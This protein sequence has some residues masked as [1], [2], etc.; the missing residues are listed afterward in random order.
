MQDERKRILAL[1]EKG[2][3]SATEALD[4]LEKIDAEKQGTAQPKQPFTTTEKPHTEQTSKHEE[5]PFSFEEEKSEKQ[6][7]DKTDEE[8]IDE[9]KKD[10]TQ[11]SSKFMDM[12]TTAVTKVR[13]FDFTGEKRQF[14]KRYELGNDAI[15]NV[16]VKV[17][18]GSFEI[19]ESSS[20]EAY[21][22]VEVVPTLL[23]RSED[24]ESDFEGLFTA[25]N[26]YGTVRLTNH[27]RTYRTNVTLFLPKKVYQHMTV[28]LSNGHFVVKHFVFDEIKVA[29]LNGKVKIVETTARKMEL[30]TSNGTIDVIDSA[31]SEVEAESTNG[32][33]SVSGTFKKIKG[34]TVNGAVQ[35]KTTDSNA[36]LM[37]AQTAA[38]SIDLQLPEATNLHGKLNSNIGQINVQ[39]EDVEHVKSE[40]QML[41]KSVRFD[42]K[43]NEEQPLEVKAETRAGSIVV[44]YAL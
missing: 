27:S 19:V 33:V 13:E 7:T 20:G 35:L 15:Q 18:N 44:R 30:E 22:E 26:D 29:S 3:I 39:L 37:K 41:S 6:K 8:F 5:A 28:D 10:F 17:P 38:G 2:V 36:E 42:K 32:S 14:T 1:V 16:S 23:V 9:L 40:D 25:E 31:G 34:S 21:A 43:V 24:V 11:F 12:F 4:L